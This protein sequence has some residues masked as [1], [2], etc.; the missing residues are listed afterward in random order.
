MRLCYHCMQQIT[1]ERAHICPNCGKSL[2]PEPQPE[3]FLTPGTV[4]GE[5]YIIGYSLGAGG[6]GNTYIGWD[7]VLQRKIAVKEFYPKQYCTRGQDGKTVI[8]PDGRLQP[9]FFRG[10]QQFLTEARSVAALHEVRGIVEISN[11]FEENGTGYIVMEYLEGMD[12]KAILERAGGKK[13]YEWCRRVILTVLYTLKEIHKRGVLHRDIAPDNIFV[14]NEGIIKLIDFGAAK[15]LSALDNTSDIMLKAGYA[16]IEQYRSDT[17]QGPYTDLYATAALFYRMLTGQKPI[18]ANERE[19]QDTLIPP[20]DMGISLPEQAE[21]AIM[22]CLNI[23][24]E[25]RLQSAEQF[26]ESLDGRFF[27]PV[28]EPEWIL[29]PVKEKVSV[30][31]KI[32]SLPVAAKA[33]LCLGCI[34]LV[35]ATVL[36][37]SVAVRSTENAEALDSRVTVMMD[38]RDKSVEE[39]AAYIDRLNIEHPRWDIKMKIEDTVFDLTKESGIVCAQSIAPGT[40]LYESGQ[41]NVS[42]TVEGLKCDE[43]GN[44]TGTVSIDVYSNEKIRYGEISGLNAYALAQKLG[45]DTTD[46]KRF[47]KVEGEEG[48]DYFDLAAVGTADEGFM[49]EELYKTE[50]QDREITYDENLKIYY[51]APDFFYWKKLPDFAGKYKTIDKVPKQQMYSFTDEKKRV[52]AEKKL[53]IGS[54][55]VDE[56]YCALKEDG[57]EEGQIIGQTVTPGETYDGSDPG[58]TL[59]E[60]QVIGTL[61]EYKGKTGAEFVDEIEDQGFDL[62]ELQTGSGESGKSEWKVEKVEIYEVDASG[63]RTDTRVDYFNRKESLRDQIMFVITVKE[64]AKPIHV[65]APEPLPTPQQVPSDSSDGTGRMGARDTNGHSFN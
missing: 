5:K 30:F 39:A 10:L 58:D 41:E 6:F 20:S 19:K 47:V 26:M 53:L 55:L 9:R 4:L 51:Y 50:N 15:Q 18:P 16:P 11:F 44:L 63:E 12:V 27:I 22:V 14:T 1:N 23:R 46:E 49:A 34:C 60:I 42:G 2:D 56:S 29:P 37:I 43:K 7:S 64:E 40:V 38:L 13:D 3:R 54:G 52:K 62:Y 31:K 57:Y 21:L 65:P 28:Y 35:G 61:F 17:A 45:I 24:P 8:V 48:K 25:Y 59:L 36:G 32:A 33:A